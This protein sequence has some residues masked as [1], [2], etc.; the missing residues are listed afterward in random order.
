MLLVVKPV[1]WRRSAAEAKNRLGSVLAFGN[2]QV[3]RR[4]AAFRKTYMDGRDLQK[5]QADHITIIIFWCFCLHLL[6]RNARFSLG[7][8]G[9]VGMMCCPDWETWQARIGYSSLPC[10]QY[11]SPLYLLWGREWDKTPLLGLP[12]FLN[13]WLLVTGVGQG[14]L[15]CRLLDEI[16]SPS[17]Y[18][19]TDSICGT[20]CPIL[21]YILHSLMSIHAECFDQLGA[22]S[23][24]R[25][26][27]RRCG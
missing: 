7:T 8:F 25:W 3:C 17:F 26:S 22:P 6:A 10:F 27:K 14:D 18:A 4:W 1:S 24:P 13:W 21:A 16:L 15:K 20:T 23:T 2:H 5:G 11:S 12:W 19:I 9:G